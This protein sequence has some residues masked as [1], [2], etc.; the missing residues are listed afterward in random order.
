MFIVYVLAVCKFQCILHQLIPC[1]VYTVQSILYVQSSYHR[2]WTHFKI[3]SVQCT[4]NMCC[5]QYTLCGYNV[6]NVNVQ[7]TSLF[8]IE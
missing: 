8:S 5:V 6:H 3:V 4:T 2:K 7:C 1:T